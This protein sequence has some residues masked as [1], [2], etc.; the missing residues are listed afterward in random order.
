MMVDETAYSRRE[1]YSAI[2]RGA[3]FVSPNGSKSSGGGAESLALKWGEN[4]IKVI[5]FMLKLH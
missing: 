4:Q 3:F 2:E 1:K 5:F